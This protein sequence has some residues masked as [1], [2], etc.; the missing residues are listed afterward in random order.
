MPEVGSGAVTRQAVLVAGGAGYI[1]SHACKCLAAAGYLPVTIDNLSTGHRWAVK[2]GPLIEADIGDRAAVRAA[3]DAHGVVAVMHFAA[4]SLV[5]ESMRDPLKYYDN[6]VTRALAFAAT[7]MD[8]G[9]RHF[10]FSSTAAVYG[11]P[12]ILPMAEDHPTKPINP[13]GATKLAFE[14]A[15][16]DL[17]GAFGLRHVILRYFNAAGADVDGEIGEAHDPETHL[18]P[19]MV[20]AALGSGPVLN[21]F[22]TDY[23]TPDGTAIRD[24]VHVVDLAHAHVAALRHLLGGGESLT[25]NIGTGEGLSVAA[26]LAKGAEVLGRAVPHRLSAR[27]E[28]DPPILVADAGAIRHRLGWQPRHSDIDTIIRTAA[29]WHSSRVAEAEVV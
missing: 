2:W 16:R 6:N 5:G 14:G 12:Q 23:P 29:A 11:M 13:Y 17:E 22:G 15:L 20:M 10:V 7:V 25:L 19:N 18:I 27:R 24:Y 1:G 28:G 3:V 9:I 4:H 8:A 21:V 26:I